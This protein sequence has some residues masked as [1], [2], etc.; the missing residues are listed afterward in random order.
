MD[1]VLILPLIILSII[2]VAIIKS[3]KDIVIP[4]KKKTFDIVIIGLVSVGILIFSIFRYVEIIDLILGVIFSAMFAVSPFKYGITKEGITYI[5]RCFVGFEEWKDIIEVK[6]KLDDLVY[7]Q[8]LG[9][10]HIEL[11]F[12]KKYYDKIIEILKINLS[13]DELVFL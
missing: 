12:D 4:T 1:L 7:L 10:K 5:G 13:D 11:K 8:I 3:V 6:I 2:L 9:R